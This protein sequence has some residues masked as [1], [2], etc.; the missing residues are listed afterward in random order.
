LERLIHLENVNGRREKT[1]Q[2]TEGN[3]GYAK[4]Y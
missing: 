1:A 3:D 4:E 2:E